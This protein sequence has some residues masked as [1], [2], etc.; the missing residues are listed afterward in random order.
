MSESSPPPPGESPPE[1]SPPPGSSEQPASSPVPGAPWPP[2][3]V[4]SA[5]GPVV[6][7]AGS[8]DAQGATMA[9]VICPRCGYDKRG[10]PPGSHCPECGASPV[11]VP[12]DAQGAIDADLPCRRCGYDLRGLRED[13]RCPECGTPIGLS[14][15]GDLLRFADPEWL[16]K[17][18]TG[19][20]I[21]LWM[22][23][24]SIIVSVGVGALR[25]YIS[26]AV[27][28]V[29]IFGTSLVS[30]YGAWLMTEPDPSGVGEDP[31]VTA[32]KVVRIAL[33]VGLVS[34]PMNVAREELS[35]G[36][37]VGI[38]LGVLLIVA[39]LVS[40]IGEFAKFIYYERLGARIPDAFIVRRARFLRWAF[41][42]CFGIMVVG[43]ALLGLAT[44]GGGPGP[45]AGAGGLLAA[46]GCIMLPA[47]IASIVF[48]VMTLFLLLRLRRA[49]AEQARV[50]RQTWVSAT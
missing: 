32:R 13:G 22:I 39:V 11:S 5:G 4:D 21:I 27:G 17:V 8:V 7:P 25:A 26:A 19:L 47:G 43:G 44:A 29:L 23:L 9:G 2:P 40:L 16:N 35:L 18:A 1:P 6:T 33:L 15:R 38:I 14:T 49:I 20:K 10:L 41:T 36:P 45:G 31:N 30:F 42:I 34:Q 48:S 46:L 37:G 3:P 50:A 28:A 24:V 12:V